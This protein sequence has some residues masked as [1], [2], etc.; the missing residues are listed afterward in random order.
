MNTLLFVT[1]LYYEAKGRTY[2]EEDLFLTSRLRESFALTICHPQDIHAFEKNYDLIVIRN[3]GPVAHFKDKYWSFRERAAANT[4]KTY[5]SFNGKG[6]M[7]GKEYLL[8]L[9]KAGYPVIPTIDDIERID[10]LP[11]VP[12]YISKPKDGADSIGLEIVS[13]NDLSSKLNAGER[14]VLIQP[15]IDFEYEVSF[16]FILRLC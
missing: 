12:S 15:F 11:Q 13:F 10:D 4:Y 9:T 6:D 2:Y 1:D 5:N 14:S 3:A 7:N 16:Y 8:E